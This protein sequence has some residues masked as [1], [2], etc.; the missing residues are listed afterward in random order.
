MHRY[1]RYGISA[2]KDILLREPS[3]FHGLVVPAHLA[4]DQSESLPAFL[5]RLGKPY[6]VDPMTFAFAV[7]GADLTNTRGDALKRSYSKLVARYHWPREIDF[8]SEQVSA[9]DFEESPGGLESS[10]EEFVN[11]VLDLQSSL[12]ELD[13]E[14]RRYEQIALGFGA[15][16]FPSRETASGP[17]FLVAPYFFFSDYEDPG[18]ALTVTAARKAVE[19]NPNNRI[20]GL[21][22]MS[23]EFLQRYDFAQLLE[24][25][26]FLRGVIIWID[27]FNDQLRNERELTAFRRLVRALARDREVINLYGGRFSMLLASDGL[28]G[29]ASGVCY[30]ES[31]V[32]VAI[33]GGVIPP[34]YY[35]SLP[36]MKLA[37]ADTLRFLK[38]Q[39][40]LCDCEICQEVLSEIEGKTP[41]WQ[42]RFVRRLFPPAG[43]GRNEAD[44][45]LK[46]HFLQSSNH[47]QRSFSEM[48]AEATLEDLRLRSE[49]LRTADPVFFNT[50]AF[51][52]SKWERALR[53]LP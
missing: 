13:E 4:A 52:L 35:A 45:R 15:E 16:L 26:Q 9:G 38:T 11:S 22:A 28:A 43:E 42:D 41:G 23:S 21:L 17:E 34:R 2:E 39:D 49:R 5:R 44:V 8:M 7:E 37:Q 14:T 19:L 48:T 20:F 6:F 50:R 47:E 12:S 3:T 51:F 32:Q 53:A 25:I 46:R 24:D 29:Y 31:K 27:G 33:S 40:D 10:M 18:Y 36:L 1:L 30:G